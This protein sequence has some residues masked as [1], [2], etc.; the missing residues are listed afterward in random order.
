MSEINYFDKVANQWDDMRKGFFPNAVREKAVEVSKIKKGD[1]A[2]DIGAGTGFISEILLDK[3]AHVIAVDQSVEMLSQL[4]KKFCCNSAL[5]IKKG[6]DTNL[7]INDNSVDFAFAN[8]YLHHVENPQIAIDEMVRILKPG[9]KSIITD[10]DEHKFDFLITEQNDRWMGFKRKDIS[11]WF[12]KASLSNV[13]IECINENRCSTSQNG[14]D[15]AEISIF[16]AE[17]IK[18]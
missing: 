5:T 12:D 1:V 16:I 14:K 2:A 13:K 8:M 15:N 6:N 3:G 11:N 7:P 17:G 18:K 4:R 10:L 9:G